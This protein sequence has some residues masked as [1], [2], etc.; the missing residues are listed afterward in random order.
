MAFTQDVTSN[1]SNETCDIL[2]N[3]KPVQVTKLFLFSVVLVSSLVGNALIIII[4][5][6]RQELHKTT[7][8]LIVNMAIS[9]FLYLLQ[10]MP[11]SLVGIASRSWYWRI[12]GTA[13]SV[14][15][16]LESY[17]RHVSSTVSME[18][19]MWIALDRFMAVV[20]PMKVHLI[21]SRF[22]VFAIPFTWIVAMTIN[23][24]D[25]FIYDLM[26]ENR[27]CAVKYSALSSYTT[28]VKLRFALLIVLFILMTISY[29]LTI[30]SLR[31]QDKVLSHAM[32][33]QVAQR[34]RH[35]ITMSI[36]IM[37]TIFICFFPML[38]LS[39]SLFELNMAM[40]CWILKE[41][42]F[43]AYFMFYLSSTVNPIICMTFAKSYRRGLRQ[44][45]RSFWTCVFA[46]GSNSIEGG[47][48]EPK[49][50]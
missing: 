18:S 42:T 40:P 10:S 26:S 15:C 2:D 14:L 23:F 48:H 11:F 3:S 50:L 36:C 4:V 30:L 22:R 9:D 16:K 21:S 13:G 49:S 39:L 47:Q 35:A 7:N 25:F 37:I 5:Y 27:M 19:L 33:H 17:L 28:L 29:S 8:Y 38:S 12:G 44:I 6:K 32:P 46:K 1:F 43:F 45:V 20:F 31:R 34:K 41:L 24:F